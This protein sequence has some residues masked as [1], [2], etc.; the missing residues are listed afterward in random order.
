MQGDLRLKNNANKKT[1]K[2]KIEQGLCLPADLTSGGCFAE[3]R[4]RGNATF[5][6]CRKILHYTPELIELEAKDC[7][8]SVR[9]KRLC[10]RS[11]CPGC[12]YIEGVIDGVN[13]TSCGGD[14]DA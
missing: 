2:E 14:S 12:T 11:F 7:I 3:I 8:I 13:Y 10:C 6:G 4:G 1:L 5:G 9:G